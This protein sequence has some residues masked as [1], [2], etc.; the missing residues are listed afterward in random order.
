MIANMMMLEWEA[1]L[2]AAV[3]RAPDGTTASRSCPVAK[4]QLNAVDGAASV[5]G[6]DVSSGGCW[7]ADRV[8]GALDVKA[9]E[10]VPE[11][12]LTVCGCPVVV[13]LDGV[14]RTEEAKTLAAEVA[15]KLLANPVIESYRIEVV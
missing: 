2:K 11:R 10:A 13:A 14:A 6:D 12:S 8:P 4:L 15:H 7:S 3:K 1:A 9:V 5:T